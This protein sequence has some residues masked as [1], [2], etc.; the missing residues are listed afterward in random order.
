MI[1]E[2]TPGPW[3]IDPKTTEGHYPIREAAGGYL[4][5]TVWRD[6]AAPELAD[7]RLI[8][9]SPDLLKALELML[10]VYAP[11]HFPAVVTN[12]FDSAVIKARAALAK[13][14]GV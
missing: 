13:A 2:H 11:I 5:A 14:R 7:A 6:D 1:A 12:A 9:A 8:A 10:A 3:A 4:I